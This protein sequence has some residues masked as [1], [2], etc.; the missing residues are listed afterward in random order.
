VLL[1]SKGNLNITKDIKTSIFAHNANLKKYLILKYTPLTEI[2]PNKTRKKLSV[3]P[4]INAKI[5]IPA[6]IVLG[7]RNA[8]NLESFK[9]IH[10]IL[11]IATV[12]EEAKEKRK[13]KAP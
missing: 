1:P 2:S 12:T 9:T 10:D 6:K 8:R 13:A 7:I 4:A 11:I 3:P 5:D